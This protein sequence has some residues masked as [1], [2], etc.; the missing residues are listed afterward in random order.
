MRPRS[1]NDTAAASTKTSLPS[2][3]RRR[4]SSKVVVPGPASRPSWRSRT[5]ARS[6]GLNKS[7]S[8]KPT[9]W[10]GAAALKSRAA[11]G[12][13]YSTT[14]AECTTIAS[15]AKSAGERPLDALL[16]PEHRALGAALLGDVASDAAVAEEFAARRD[17]RLARDD[18]D[19]PRAALVGALDLEV[20][21]RQL[22]AQAL[23]MRFERARL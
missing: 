3:Q 5:R 14:R 7:S 6:A 11:A 1:R 16:R 21:E 22:L 9:S 12:L 4:R 10:R 13:A 2:T 19:Q 23:Q 17:P 20:E 15:G 18:V 8:L